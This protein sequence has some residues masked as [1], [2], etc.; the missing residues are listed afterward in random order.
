MLANI[1][2]VHSFTFLIGIFIYFQSPV[3]RYMGFILVKECILLIL[4]D[5]V[6]LFLKVVLCSVTQSCTTLCNPMNGSTPGFPVLHYLLMFAQTHVHW[7][8]AMQTSHPLSPHS[9]PVLTLSQCQFLFQRVGS[10]HQLA[11]V[12]ASASVLPMNIQGWFPLG[13]TGWSP[14]YPRDY[15]E[16]S[17]AL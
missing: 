2:S 13:L 6:K 3:E 11:R 16:S 15:Q 7:V 5:I 17:L 4:L 12:L 8:N 14:C 9:P 1:I 10:L